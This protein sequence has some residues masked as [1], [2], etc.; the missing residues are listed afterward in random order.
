MK[1]G[2]HK[3]S[4]RWRAV[5]YRASAFLRGDR[6]ERSGLLMDVFAA[7]LWTLDF[8][9]FVFRKGQ[10]GFERPVAI[11]AVKL[12][13]GHGDLRCTP[14]GIEVCPTMYAR[15]PRG[16]KASCLAPAFCAHPV[17]GSPSWCSPSRSRVDFPI[18]AA[19][20]CVAKWLP[21]YGWPNHLALSHPRKAR[22]RRDGCGL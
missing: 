13:A 21:H 8:A 10:D 6:K 12:I 3:I 17:P 18:G 5:C 9:L 15:A 14:E 4:F 20:N 1:Q 2:T 16:V 7:A 22:W 19:Q 11:F